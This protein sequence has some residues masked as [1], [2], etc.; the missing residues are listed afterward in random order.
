MFG[1]MGLNMDSFFLICYEFKDGKRYI[2]NVDMDADKGSRTR[3]WTT[4]P[5]NAYRFKEQID[6]ELVT[7]MFF[8][9]DDL[10]VCVVAWPIYPHPFMFGG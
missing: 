8:S 1:M 7:E 10:A 6:A 9:K 2:H 3:I 4:Q 5:E